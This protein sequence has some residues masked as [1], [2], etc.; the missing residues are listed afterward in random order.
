[1]KAENEN[2][3]ASCDAN[4]TVICKYNILCKFC[5]VGLSNYR[6]ESCSVF[7]E[8]C[9]GIAK[10]IFM[11]FYYLF[12]YYM[13]IKMGCYSRLQYKHVCR[14][15]IYLAYKSYS[16]VKLVVII[17]FDSAVLPI[18]HKLTKFSGFEEESTPKDNKPTKQKTL[19][20]SSALL[21]CLMLTPLPH[22]RLVYE[23]ER[24]EIKIRLDVNP[25]PI[26]KWYKDGVELKPSHRIKIEYYGGVACLTYSSVIKS[27]SGHYLVHV[28]NSKGSL[29]S[30]MDFSVE[31]KLFGRFYHHTEFCCSGK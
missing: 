11:F 8:L 2:G 6:L 31:C 15:F 10:T 27:D 26:I 22:T 16:S 1:M 21:K 4:V 7:K 14:K 25:E 29:K 23:G 24:I 17:I 19:P 20:P 28:V 13:D 3:F 30:E 18:E 9:D 12:H 5:V